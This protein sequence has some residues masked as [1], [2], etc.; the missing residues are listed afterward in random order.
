MKEEQRQQIQK[1]F[2]KELEEFSMYGDGVPSHIWNGITNYVLDGQPTGYFLHAMLTNDLAGVM[3]YADDINIRALHA[4]YG[5]FYNGT[6]VPSICW[7]SEDKVKAWH[8][9]GGL[10]GMEKKLITD[11]GPKHV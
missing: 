3:R 5:F 6:Y 2:R 11:T 9:K 10:F 1:Q 4:I 7:G 8:E